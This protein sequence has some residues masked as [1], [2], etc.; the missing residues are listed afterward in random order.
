MVETRKQAAQSAMEAQMTTSERNA[1]S[2]QNLEL[3]QSIDNKMKEMRIGMMADLHKLFGNHHGICIG[4]GVT[5]EKNHP[6]QTPVIV[7]ERGRGESNPWK[8][9]NTLA[10]VPGKKS[11]RFHQLNWDQYTNLLRER[12]SPWGL[13]DPFSELLALRQ[14]ESMEQ[15]Y[16]EFIHLLNQ[17]QLPDEYVLSLFKITY[18]WKLV[19]ICSC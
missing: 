13:E 1:S 8:Q 14:N 9:P 10:S 18:G 6:T 2:K 19:N 4:E 5:G 12:F 17:I 15:F 11:E 3:E 7:I 16:E